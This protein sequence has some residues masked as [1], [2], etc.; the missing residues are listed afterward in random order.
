M[1][2]HSATL[3]LLTVALALFVTPSIGNVL[4]GDNTSSFLDPLSDNSAETWPTR[5][6]RNLSSSVCT[7]E[8]ILQQRMRQVGARGKAR[9]HAHKLS[10]RR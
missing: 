8:L 1:T 2:M 6:S 4:R 7:H 10:S 3:S 9:T 5:T